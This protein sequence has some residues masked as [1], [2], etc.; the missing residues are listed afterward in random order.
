M[1]ETA[2][3]IQ[4]AVDEYAVLIKQ[5]TAIKERLETLKAAFEKRAVTELK[6]TK[7]KQAVYW[8][9]ADAR[10]VVTVSETVKPV[11]VTMIKDVLGRVSGDFVKEEV[12]ATLTDPG[13]RLLAMVFQGD[14]T[15]SSLDDLIKGISEDTEIQTTLRKKLKGRWSK[16]AKALMQVVGLDEAAA[17]DYAY[18]AAEVIG[19][20]WLCQ[21]LKAAGWQGSVQS[22]IETL[23]SAVIV[24]ESIKVGIE[25][26]K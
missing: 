2:Q 7:L 19:W 24:D 1:L 11:S 5:Q 22:A 3:E 20:E 12:K 14:Y 21:I 10:V 6:D 13:K 23:R 15:E 8:G 17:G 16:D 9:S 4:N 26:G 18:L 25:I